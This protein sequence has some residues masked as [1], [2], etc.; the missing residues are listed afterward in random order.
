M[1]GRM[2]AAAR[3]VRRFRARRRRMAANL[4]RANTLQAYEEVF[5][6]PELLVEY[7][8]PARRAFYAEVAEVVADLEPRW[9]CD[10]GCGTGHL[11]RAVIDRVS[12]PER[13]V[14]VDQ[15]RAGIAQLALN[16]PSAEGIVGDVFELPF[17]DGSFDVVLCTE[18]LEHVVRPRPLLAELARVCR[19][20]G[21]LVLT[22]PDGAIDDWEGHVN[23]WSAAEFAAFVGTVGEA[24]VRRLNGGDLL[25]LVRPH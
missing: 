6:S 24:S 23:F 3:R 19:T 9:L 11:L 10:A 17:E 13:V 16:V 2:I 21:T 1:A 20:G 5:G 15:T 7:L 18:V 4:T 14:G 25:G 12:P 8:D 22:V